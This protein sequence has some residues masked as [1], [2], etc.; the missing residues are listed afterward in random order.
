MTSP[1]RCR[2]SLAEVIA[3]V[4]PWLLRWWLELRHWLYEWPPDLW[5]SLWI[6]AAM[7]AEGIAG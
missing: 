4:E 7:G 3:I 5:Q 1:L 6:V 2:L